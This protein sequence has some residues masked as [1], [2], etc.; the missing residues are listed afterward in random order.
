VK[1]TVYNGLLTS[2]RKSRDCYGWKPTQESVQVAL[3]LTPS[4]QRI[5]RRRTWAA[6]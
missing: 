4:R 6:A 3:G 1:K 5:S 2:V